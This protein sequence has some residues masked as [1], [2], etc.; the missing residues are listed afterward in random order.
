[1]PIHLLPDTRIDRRAF[2][3][4]LA[5]SALAPGCA[6][7]AGADGNPG[8]WYAWLSDTHIA[9]DP[10]R[11][12]NGEVMTDNLRAVVAEILAADEPPRGVL[13]NGDVAYH[14][15]QAGD[16]RTFLDA[17]APLRR[18]G[19]PIHLTLGN[20]D[21]RSNLIDALG[22]GVEALA[23][24]R[25]GVVPG[26]GLRFLLLDSQDGVNVTAG[27][28]GEE[29]C[30]WLAGTLDEKPKEPAVIFVHHNLNAESESALRDT[31]ALLD[32]VRPR[33]QAKAVIFGHTHVWNPRKIEDVHAINIPAVGYKFLKKQPIGWV[34][35]RPRPDGGELELRCIGGD[36]RQH[37]RRVDLSWRA[38]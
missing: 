7:R 2:L 28:L 14:E 13:V 33:R 6:G 11:K 12:Q 29:Q 30:D 38:A 8:G 3:A 1:M 31:E 23:E 26:P 9:A 35:F 21:D 34:V 22:P 4:G 36:R 18:A 32:V 15:G 27:R 37:G 19:I 5:A 10:A 17:T 24:K 20:H 25:V 16:Y